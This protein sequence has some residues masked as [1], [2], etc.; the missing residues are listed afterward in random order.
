MLLADA[1]SANVLIVQ[2]DPALAERIGQIVLAGTPD[3]A[4]GSVPGPLEAIAALEY[5]DDIALCVCELFYTAGQGLDFLAAIR[6]RF[7]RARVII[8]SNYNL[9]NFAD[10]IQ[11]LTVFPLPLDE[12]V[13]NATCRDALAT[14]EG[15]VFPPFR[16][17]QKQPP[18]RWGDCYEAYDMGVKRDV[19][20]TVCHSWATPEDAVRFRSFAALMARASHPNVQAVYQA[21]EYQERDYFAREK[22]DM[23]NLAEMAT[24][25]QAIDPRQAAQIIHIVGSVVIFW[26]SNQYSHTA[27]GATDVSL[28]PQG[29]IKVANCVDPT[30]P[31]KPVGLSDLTALAQAVLALLPP[32]DQLP[33]RVSKLLDELRAGPVPV[34]PMVS[35][36]QAIDL[37]L[38]PEREIAVS[39][40]HH[41][42]RQAIQV[43]RRSQ[44][45][46]LYLSFGLFALVVAVVGFIFYSRLDPPSH[47][48][49]EMIEIPAG[50]YMY[51]DAPATLDHTFYIDKYEVT[52]GKYL[53]F[54]RAVQNAGGDEAWRSSDQPEDKPPDHEPK[55]WANIFTCIKERKPYK[56]RSDLL[57]L[58]DPVFNVDWYDAEAYAKWAGKRLPTEY[59]WEK[60]ARGTEGNLYPWGNVYA[61][62]ANTNMVPPGTD[63]ST[64]PMTAHVHKA[65]DQMPEDKSP[66]GVYDMAGNVSEWTDTL[67]PGSKP[68]LGTVAVIRGGNL[69]TSIEDHAMVIYRNTDWP[70]TTRD[71]WLGFR[72][73]SDTPPK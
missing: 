56:S 72:C 16:L 23:P 57:T 58:D 45:R 47:D 70:Q 30:Q 9:M 31:S 28:S 60:A 8:V 3:A 6:A 22:W 39:E 62:K 63:R 69:A 26:D 11:G 44:A 14:M 32:P 46:N 36:A 68:S 49:T 33:L 34:A 52:F 37:E 20:I 51:Q 13:L 15:Q 55:D 64:M 59:E 1:M 53:K 10:H 71:F 18:D 21:G 66:F 12:A 4:V 43:A 73:V 42:A 17:G 5:Y 65:V 54:L 48:F 7:R 29:V 27:V 19:F 2:P 40:E 24:A 35:E 38:T 61:P 50:P 25:G 41:I 67:V